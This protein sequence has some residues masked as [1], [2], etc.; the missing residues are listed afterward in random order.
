MTAPDD[1]AVN[2]VDEAHEA[3]EI[4]AFLAAEDVANDYHSRRLA[5]EV[6]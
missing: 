3:A 5:A 1:T 6:D 2:G 4:A